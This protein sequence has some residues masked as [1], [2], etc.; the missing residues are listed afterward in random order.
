MPGNTPTTAFPAQ[1]TSPGG[2]GSGIKAAGSRA[3]PGIKTLGLP[4]KLEDGA[5]DQRLGPCNCTAGIVDQIPGG[6]IV[7]AVDHRV[8]FMG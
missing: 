2:G 1:G 8:V 5:V 3:L 4:F 7:R 6:I